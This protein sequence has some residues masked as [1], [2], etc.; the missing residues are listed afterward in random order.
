MEN[1][2]TFFPVGSHSFGYLF[3]SSPILASAPAFLPGQ[4]GDKSE[5]PI[6]FEMI[7]FPFLLSPT[8]N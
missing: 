6:K 7:H 5:Q 8:F 3:R 4:Q 1:S 2:K